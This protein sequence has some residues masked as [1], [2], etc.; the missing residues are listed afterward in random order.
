MRANVV[1]YHTSDKSTSIL[2]ECNT[3]TEARAKLNEYV[4]Q[5]RMNNI[6]M[7]V[8][9]KMRKDGDRVEFRYSTWGVAYYVEQV[10][11]TATN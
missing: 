3:L 1:F 9:A 2:D 11:Q 5:A 6:K 7:G 8:T 10:D 4:H